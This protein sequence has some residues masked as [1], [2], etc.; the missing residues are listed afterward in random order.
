MLHRVKHTSFC[1][2]PHLTAAHT[3]VPPHYAHQMGNLLRVDGTLMGLDD[4]TR[5]LIPRWKRG[6]FSLLVDAGAGGVCVWGVG[7][8]GGGR[9]GAPGRAR[10]RSAVRRTLRFVTLEKRGGEQASEDQPAR[11]LLAEAWRPAPEAA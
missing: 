1:W 6:H 9:G 8:W 3:L 5:S 7:G 11:L 10:L 2:L 4:Q